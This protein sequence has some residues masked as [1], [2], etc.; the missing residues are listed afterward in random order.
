MIE[1]RR[2]NPEEREEVVSLSKNLNKY[3][4][5]FNSIWTR[6]KMW[7]KS[8]P[9]VAVEAGKIIGFHAAS[10]LKKDY[11]YTLYIGVSPSGSGKGVAKSLTWAAIEH[12]QTLGLTRFTAK[13]D[14]RGDGFAFYTGLGMKPVARK[15]T[16]FTFDC[17]FSDSRSMEEFRDRLKSGTACTAPN[18]RKQALYKK[19]N[20][21]IFF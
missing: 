15:G 20:E 14:T 17:E 5:E 12:A 18:Q 3:V 6:W 21:E 16:E 1:I 8:P 2:M 13:A 7:D 11:V 10:F 4:K 9:F 19:N